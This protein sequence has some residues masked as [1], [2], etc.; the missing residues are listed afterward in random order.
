VGAN[1]GVTTLAF[2]ALAPRGKVF[3]FEPIPKTFQYLQKNIQTN[4][5]RCAQIAHIEAINAACGPATGR[6][7]IFEDAFSAGSFMAEYQSK[8][9]Q[10][11]AIE[12][13]LVSLDEIA[14]RAALSRLD[15]VKI[16]VEGF[17][18][19]VLHG[20]TEIL[21]LYH[22]TVIL[23]FNSYC[24]IVNAYTLPNVFLANI[25]SQFSEV[26]A[27]NGSELHQI[28]TVGDQRAAL[29]TNLIA[30]G[31][32]DNLVC[33]PRHSEY[34]SALERAPNQKLD[35]APTFVRRSNA[36]G[37]MEMNF[38]EPFSGIG[39]DVGD[40]GGYARDE[41]CTINL[42]LSRVLQDCELS[43]WAD[44]HP[45]TEDS[46]IS[47]LVAV[48]GE[49]LGEWLV[50]PGRQVS[51]SLDIPAEVVSLRHMMEL[52]FV[53]T[54]CL[55]PCVGEAAPRLRLLCKKLAINPIKGFK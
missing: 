32:V 28:G 3:S 20:M 37:G 43:V 26:F 16:D 7:R 21:N 27:V 51:Y 44:V 41:R 34:T 33:F 18:A 19:S 13:D 48:N 36:T 10:R 8:E 38:S 29:A 25:C 30:H 11:A 15:L 24:L 14:K 22:P 54:R 5:G 40:A 47:V 9:L 31:C 45:P 39:W 35:A 1:I 50:V 12:V 17:E 42:N 49:P 52:E 46:A 4:F 2:A 23:E 55:G 53:T 6:A